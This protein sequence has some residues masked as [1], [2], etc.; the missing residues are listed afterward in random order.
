M[1]SKFL[2]KLQTLLLPYHCVLCH[3]KA[4]DYDLCEACKADLPH[5]EKAC[6]TCAMPLPVETSQPCGFCQQ[7]SPF[8]DRTISVFYYQDPINHMM[9]QFKFHQKLLYGKLFS[10]LLISKIQTELATEELP[11]IILPIP[12]HASRLRERG[13]NQALELARPLAKVL[14]LN[15]D[16]TSLVRVRATAQQALTDEAHREKNVKGAFRLRKKLNVKHVGLIDDVI[17]TA[18]TMNE[19]SRVLKEAGVEKITLLAV[20]R[21]TL[22]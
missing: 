18:H 14:K 2:K 12:L 11:D 8:Y 19:C 16:Y 7:K 22:K 15:L 10:N 13:Y 1:I 5:I 20:A 9:S 4:S 21:T 6:S 17:T 3:N